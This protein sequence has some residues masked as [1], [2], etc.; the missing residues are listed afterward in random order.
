MFTG[1]PPTAGPVP[2]WTVGFTASPTGAL[3]KGD[4][5]TAVV[6]PGFTVPATPTVTLASGFTNYS[7]TATAAAQ[8]VT[9]TLA[10]NAGTCAVAGSAAASFKVLGL[11][12]PT[13]ATYAANTFSVKT[14]PDITAAN[15]GS[16]VTIGAAALPATVTF[17]GSPQTALSRSA[18]TV[19]FQASATGALPA[20]G[21]PTALFPPGFPCPVSPPDR[22]VTRF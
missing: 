21:P 1:A 5:I 4:T 18:W 8:T 19:G 9:V 14:S 2:A 16:T 22:L 3:R 11:T 12:N 10:D 15:P 17:A 20:G 7:A 6:N 13:A